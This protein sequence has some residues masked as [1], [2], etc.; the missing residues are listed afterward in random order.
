[1]AEQQSADPE[2]HQHT[3]IGAAKVYCA[4]QM[5]SV[6]KAPRVSHIYKAISELITAS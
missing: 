1:M 4:V 3:L 6:G 2:E 5:A